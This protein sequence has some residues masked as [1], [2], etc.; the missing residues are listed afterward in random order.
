MM[1]IANVSGLGCRVWGL[2]FGVLSLGCRDWVS[3]FWFR[4]SGTPKRV[5]KNRSNTHSEN[6]RP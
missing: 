6:S 3:G 5:T 1:D 4:A 2:G